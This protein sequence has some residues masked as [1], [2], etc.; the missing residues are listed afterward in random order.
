ML[1]A[2]K[3]ITT[4]IIFVGFWNKLQ[5]DCF[6]YVFHKEKA[7]Q[8]RLFSALKQSPRDETNNTDPVSYIQPNYQDLMT[9]K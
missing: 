7:K 9:I 8:R 1:I 5:S 6:D 2:M 4:L 3:F